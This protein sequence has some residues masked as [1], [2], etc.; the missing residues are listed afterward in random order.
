MS[1]FT[2][3]SYKVSKYYIIRHLSLQ[4]GLSA[5]LSMG[6]R[7]GNPVAS[8]NDYRTIGLPICR[9][10]L[11]RDS[12]YKPTTCL[13]LASQSGE[14]P[15]GPDWRFASPG[16]GNVHFICCTLEDLGRPRCT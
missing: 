5:D 8:M 7:Y 11:R 15:S 3:Q 16:E 2:K 4:T 6:L 1:I 10:E 13:H 14:E 9:S 12:I